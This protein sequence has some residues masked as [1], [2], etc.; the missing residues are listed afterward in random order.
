MGNLFFIIKYL[1]A[2]YLA[3]LG[4]S[5]ILSNDNYAEAQASFPP[6]HLTSFSAGL[7]TTLSNPKAI[8]FYASIFPAFIN[9]TELTILEAT[10]LYTLAAVAVGGVMLGYAYLSCMA[11]SLYRPKEKRPYLRYASG[12]MLLG[13]GLYIAIRS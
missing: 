5:L 1:A 13:S 4:I 9:L 6:N 11:K 2:A 10:A 7:I 12:A 8:L 3:W